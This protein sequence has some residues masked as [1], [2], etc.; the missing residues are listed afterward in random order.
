MYIW[1]SDIYNFPSSWRISFN[2]FL[3]CRSPGNAYLQF[4][5]LLEKSSFPFTLKGQF[6]GIQKSKLMSLCLFASFFFQHFK[7]FAPVFS[8][9]HSLWTEA[10]FAIPYTCR[11]QRLKFL[12][13][14]LFSF[15]LLSLGFPRGFLN[16]TV[17]SVVLPESCI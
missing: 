8:C 5:L 7:Y 4:L 13:K 16:K 11:Y 2:I 1:V 10:V 17:L 6:Y 9:L 3:Q 14:S 15:P 12:H